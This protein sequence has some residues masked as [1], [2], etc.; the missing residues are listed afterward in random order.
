[1]KIPGLRLLKRHGFKVGLLSLG[2]GLAV[3]V[4]TLAFLA[5]ITNDM[6]WILWL[7]SAALFGSAVWVGARGGGLISILLLCLPLMTVFGVLALSQGPGLWPHLVFWLLFSL[8]GWLGFRPTGRH[9]LSALLAAVVLSAAG[10]WYCTAYVPAELARTLNHFR[11]DP[12]PEFTLVDLDGTPYA[13]ESLDGKV[14]VLD[15]FAT[16]CAPCIAELPEIEGVRMDL[17]DHEDVVILVVANDSGGD[18]PDSIRAFVEKNGVGLPFVY[19]PEGKAHAAFGFA[20]LPGLVVMDRSRQI[21]L[22][23]EG[24][25]A[26]EIHFR[27]DLVSLVEELL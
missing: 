3:M 24:Y 25:N 13:M 19:D 2:L 9:V 14:V 20:G 26:A 16:W 12:A 21:R 23:R 8:I 1:M 27:E 4:G 18:T 5:L 22:T 7:G 17:S 10:V 6:R 15:F 11:D